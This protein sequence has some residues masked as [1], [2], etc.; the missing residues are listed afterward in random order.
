[1]SCRKGR[2]RPSHHLCIRILLDLLLC[3][4]RYEKICLLHRD[5]WQRRQETFGLCL[6]SQFGRI[7]V[8]E[9]LWPALLESL[10][11]TSHILKHHTQWCCSCSCWGIDSGS[12]ESTGF[13]PGST[14]CSRPRAWSAQSDTRSLSSTSLDCSM[15]FLAA[16]LTCWRFVEGWGTCKCP[17]LAPLRRVSPPLASWTVWLAG[18]TA[19]PCSSLWTLSSIRGEDQPWLWPSYC[20]RS[21]LELTIRRHRC[22]D[23]LTPSG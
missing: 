13:L 19:S 14:S 21:Y 7:L 8:Q 15:G 6:H 11:L 9:I 23:P 20:Y 17:Q 16:S 18:G 10:S 22:S 5:A 3:N 12:Q 1:M 2:I 4:S